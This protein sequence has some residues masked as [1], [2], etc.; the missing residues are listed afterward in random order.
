MNPKLRFSPPL[1][2]LP[3][4]VNLLSSRVLADEETTELSS[5]DSNQ[6]SQEEFY[7]P[8]VVQTVHLDIADEEL[9]RMQDALPERIYV[10]AAFRWRDIEVERVAGEIQRK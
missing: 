8:A 4:V 9:Q 3:L 7:A 1:I 5:P 10:P 2:C 6:L